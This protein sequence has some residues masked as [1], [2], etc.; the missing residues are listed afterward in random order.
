MSFT[1]GPLLMHSDHV[2]AEARDALRAAYEGPPERRGAL[3]ESAARIL[4]AETELECDDARELVGLPVD[5]P[6][7]R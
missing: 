2:P 6:T 7:C 4:Y 5:A 1:L 3:L